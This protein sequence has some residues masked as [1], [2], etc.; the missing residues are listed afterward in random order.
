MI[1][2]WGNG[3]E[4]H[5]NFQELLKQRKITQFWNYPR[6]PKMNVY[7]ERFNRSIQEEFA[8]YNLIT[9]RDN[10]A[11]FNK[12]LQDYLNFYNCHRPHLGLQKDT[13][14]F[15]L[16]MQHLKQYHQMRYIW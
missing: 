11:E 1:L 6:S 2:E 4:N 16:P 9:L 8:N 12:E 14:Q 13:G 3:Q 15:I 7:V 10:I 5:K